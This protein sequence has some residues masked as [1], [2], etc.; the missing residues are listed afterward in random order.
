MINEVE[1]IRAVLKEQA[2]SICLFR[3]GDFYEVYSDQAQIVS[4]QLGLTLMNKH[5]ILLMCG[6]PYHQLDNYVRKLIQ[7]GHKVAV[8]EQGKG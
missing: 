1:N 2:G 4:K 5:N 7:L 8:C 3:V 6:F